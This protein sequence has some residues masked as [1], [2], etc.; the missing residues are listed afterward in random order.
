M[1]ALRP[2]FIVMYDADLELMREIE[3]YRASQR[4]LAVRVYFLVYDNSVDVQKYQ[5]AVA[6]EREAFQNLIRENSVRLLQSS[7]FCYGLRVLASVWQVMVLPDYDMEAE[8]VVREPSPVPTSARQGGGEPLTTKEVRVAF[9]NLFV[10][11]A[12][13]CDSLSLSFST[14]GAVG[15]RGYA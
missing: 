15:D 6:R 4:G 9:F 11:A 2:N 13:L 10:F 7:R 1:Q 14:Y 5:H 8:V 3:V 12:T